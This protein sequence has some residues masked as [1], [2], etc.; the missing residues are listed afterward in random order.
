[1]LTRVH[2][3][4]TMRWVSWT[5]ADKDTIKMVRYRNPVISIDSFKSYPL[6]KYNVSWQRVK[7]NTLCVTQCLINLTFGFW[8]VIFLDLVLKNHATEFFLA[9]AFNV[10]SWL[11]AR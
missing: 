4:N 10:D 2:C 3:F 11:V 7:E 8:T 1:M 6:S 5:I 9:S